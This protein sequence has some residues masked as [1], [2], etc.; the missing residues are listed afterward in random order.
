MTDRLAALGAIVGAWT[1]D[2]E[3]LLA[4]FRTRFTADPLV[5]DKWLSLNA[6]S[7]DAGTVDRLKAILAEPD[8]PRN[9]PNRLRSLAAVFGMNNPTQFAR[10][11]GEGFRFLTQFVTDVDGRNPQVAARVLTAFRI[12]Q[13]FEPGRREAARLAM[14]ALKDAGNLSRNTA[15]IL[16][17]TLAG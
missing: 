2:A 6:Q 5:L 11:D 8:F 16:D 9:N 14:Q 10:A 3:P 12:W 17:R 15:E 7:P 1:A 4:D 13:S